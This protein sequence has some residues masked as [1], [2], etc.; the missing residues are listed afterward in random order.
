VLVEECRGDGGPVGEAAIEGRAADTCGFGDL[1]HRDG[2]RVALAEE[3]LGGGQDLGAIAHRVGALPG[4]R[5][6]LQVA[7]GDD[8][9]Y[10]DLVADAHGFTLLRSI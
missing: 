3:Q 1:V 7:W 8:G 10:R 2:A 6:G 5:A 4:R 9:R